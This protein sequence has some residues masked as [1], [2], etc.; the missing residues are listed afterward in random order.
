MSNVLTRHIA[1]ETMLAAA[2]EIDR[3]VAENEKL[4]GAL[5]PFAKH[6]HATDHIIPGKL[7]I[8]CENARAALSS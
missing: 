4:R 6:A 1:K 2:D 8:W 5:M 3:L 7:K